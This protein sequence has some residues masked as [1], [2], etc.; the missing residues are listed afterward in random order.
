MSQ[1]VPGDVQLAQC[2]CRE[3]SICFRLKPGLLGTPN[4]SPYCHP[5]Q[6][7]NHAHGYGGLENATQHAALLDVGQEILIA[8]NI[9]EWAPGS[10]TV[11]VPIP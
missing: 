2:A 9:T 6:T 10:S 1:D 3:G 4:W 11:E 8:G 5:C 7:G